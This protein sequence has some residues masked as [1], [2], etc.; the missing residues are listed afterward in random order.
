MARLQIFLLGR[1]E[2]V[3]DGI[4]VTGFE[5][6][7]V[8]ALLATLAAE[9][10]HPQRREA[11]AALLWPDWPPQAAMSN[12]RYALADLRKNLGDR[13]AQRPFCSSAAPASNST[14]RRMCGWTLAN[15]SRPRSNQ[16]SAINNPQF[17]CIA[18]HS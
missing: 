6:H 1:L 10:D 5:S 16:K 13:E 7:K 8:R 3:L 14:R 11:L 2:C 4:Q 18:A 12:L 9:R 17:R 15:L